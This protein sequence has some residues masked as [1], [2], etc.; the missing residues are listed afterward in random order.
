MIPASLVNKPSLLT[1]KCALATVAL[2]TFEVA[3]NIYSVVLCFQVSKPMFEYNYDLNHMLLSPSDITVYVRTVAIL[4]LALSTTSLF[5][6]G[7]V[8]VFTYSFL[9]RSK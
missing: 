9:I 2:K 5:L 3:S 6:A 7:C 8:F 1:L 4:L